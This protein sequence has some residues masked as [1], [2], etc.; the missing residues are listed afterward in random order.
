MSIRVVI[1]NNN[2]LMNNVMYFCTMFKCIHL[3]VNAVNVY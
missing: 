2:E 1:D 3:R